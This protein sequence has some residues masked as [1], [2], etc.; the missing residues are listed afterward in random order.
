MGGAE[1]WVMRAWRRAHYTHF[2]SLYVGYGRTIIM[3]NR[4]EGETWCRLDD[5]LLALR[6]T[7]YTRFI[8]FY[9]GVVHLD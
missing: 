7:L 1:I 9:V 5:E 3:D 6:I 4:L 2:S 8:H